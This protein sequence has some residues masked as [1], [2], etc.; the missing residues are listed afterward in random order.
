MCMYRTNVRCLLGSTCVVHLSNTQY[1]T[2]VQKMLWTIAIYRCNNILILLAMAYKTISSLA[3]S[4]S[5]MQLE[6]LL[7]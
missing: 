1:D 6:D 2:N 4:R 3:H 7:V 5:T